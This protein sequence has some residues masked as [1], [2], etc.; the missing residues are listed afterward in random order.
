MSRQK[1]DSARRAAWGALRDSVVAIATHSAT[2]PLGCQ[3]AEERARN[4]AQLVLGREDPWAPLGL[5][6]TVWVVEAYAMLA[7]DPERSVSL[8]EDDAIALGARVAEAVGRL[9]AK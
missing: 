4:V 8:T 3:V 9:L 5:A 7:W 1:Q 6:E 2:G